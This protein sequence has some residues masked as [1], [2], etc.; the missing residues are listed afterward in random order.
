MIR[1]LI[2]LFIIPLCL[3]AQQNE[4]I[5]YPEDSS[6]ELLYVGD[7]KKGEFDTTLLN[8]EWWGLYEK[9]NISYLRKVELRLDKI[10]PDIQYDWEYSISV[11]DSKNCI[12]LFAGLEL[13]ERDIDH[14]TD[15]DMIRNNT[16][17]TFEFGPYH[18]YLSSKLESTDSIGEVERRDYSVHLN[19]QSNNILATQELFVFPC[20]DSQLLISLVWAGDLDDDGKTDFVI[21]LPTP[22]HNEMGDSTGLF[23]SSKSDPKELVRLV[24]YLISTGC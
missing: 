18:T 12:I 15:N 2:M 20:Y 13:V 23:L 17:F 1:T 9:N 24:A 14:Y 16:D 8:R 3:N 22:P 7:Y 19:Y 10:E 4:L 6:I 11:D 21:Q 5:K